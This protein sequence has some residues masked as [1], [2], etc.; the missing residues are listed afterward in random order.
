MYCTKCIALF[1]ND[2]Y[3][4]SQKLDLVGAY[5]YILHIYKIRC[6]CRGDGVILCLSIFDHFRCEY[7]V[8]YNFQTSHIMSKYSSTIKDDILRMSFCDTN[9]PINRTARKF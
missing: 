7:F 5:R 6:R 9:G 1:A 8:G 4:A 2:D 3:F